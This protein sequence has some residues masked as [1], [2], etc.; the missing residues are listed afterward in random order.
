MSYTPPSGN[1]VD[2]QQTGNAYS[3]PAGNSVDF[4]LV[5][6]GSAAVSIPFSGTASGAYGDIG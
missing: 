4:N 5:F 1:A 6:S 3:S 2:F